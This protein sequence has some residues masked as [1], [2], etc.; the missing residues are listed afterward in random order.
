M[1]LNQLANL[2]VV[3]FHIVKSHHSNKTSFTVPYRNHIVVGTIANIPFIIVFV[4]VTHE[5][6][7]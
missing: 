5:Y 3:T 7:T 4:N 2:E 6:A 1:L